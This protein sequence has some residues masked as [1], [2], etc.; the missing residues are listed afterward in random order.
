MSRA[1]ITEGNYVSGGSGS[2]TILTTVVSVDPVYVYADID[3]DSFLKFNALASS[4]KIERDAEGL[5]PVQLQ[6]ADEQ[7]FQHQGYIESLDNRLDQKTGT[8]LLR[9]VF[10]NETGRMVPG[11]FAR[12]RIPMSAR[13]P[14]P[15]SYSTH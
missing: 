15:I 10:T 2:G 11:L 9:A 8:I 13:H 6:L 4:G 3:E 7:G 1:L 5:T 12:I 14:A